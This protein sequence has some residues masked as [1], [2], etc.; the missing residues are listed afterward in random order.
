MDGSVERKPAF[1]IPSN[2]RVED[3]IGSIMQEA[4][5]V[6]SQTLFHKLVLLKLKENDGIPFRLSAKRLRRIA[7]N[8]KDIDLIIHCRVGKRSSNMV[9]C[10][11]CGSKM[12]D[13]KNSTLYGWTV[14]TGK[15]CPVCSYWTGKKKR[16]PTRYVFTTEKEKYLGEKMEVK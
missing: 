16:I 3:I 10:P 1:R 11:V 7:A 8:M 6:R 2:S 4:L 15:A 5:T 9:N 14:Q 12:G 13:I